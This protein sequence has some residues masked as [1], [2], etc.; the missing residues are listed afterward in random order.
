MLLLLAAGLAAAS[1]ALGFAPLIVEPV[2]SVDPVN[3]GST[4]FRPSGLPAECYTTV[5]IW[6]VVAK[7]GLALAMALALAGAMTMLVARRRS[8][9]SVTA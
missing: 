9:P 6:A 5:D 8:A 1:A 3:C 4:W 2:G 7:G